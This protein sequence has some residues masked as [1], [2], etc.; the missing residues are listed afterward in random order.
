MTGS[1][2]TLGVSKQPNEGLP[3]KH[4]ADAA[5]DECPVHI[6]PRCPGADACGQNEEI[7]PVA[8][9]LVELQ[10]AETRSQ[11]RGAGTLVVSTCAS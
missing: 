8:E 1:G 9:F 11:R 4:G 10:R 3:L 2:E 6:F 7:F 5:M